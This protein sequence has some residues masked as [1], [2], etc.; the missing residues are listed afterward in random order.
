MF[1]PPKTTSELRAYL[2]ELMGKIESGAVDA[3]D[4]KV[5]ISAAGVINDSF[6]VE[7]QMAALEV[8]LTGRSTAI[9][10]LALSAETAPKA[11]VGV[12]Q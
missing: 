3:A 12:N 4:A 11:Q 5:I 7:L 6:A 10:A 2:A 8:R 1:K 9:G